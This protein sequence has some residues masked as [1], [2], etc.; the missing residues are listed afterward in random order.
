MTENENKALVDVLLSA[1][2]LQSHASPLRPEVVQ[3]LADSSI[4]SVLA[5]IGHAVHYGAAGAEKLSEIYEQLLAA[6]RK[7]RSPV[8]ELEP[9]PQLWPGDLVEVRTGR[10]AA[11]K[12]QL[13]VV[14]VGEDVVAVAPRELSYD[15]VLSTVPLGDVSRRRDS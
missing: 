7:E 4:C 5:S 12:T 13:R 11:S 10:Y 15:Y 14:W 9:G 8:G 1:L 3:L 2:A 6:L